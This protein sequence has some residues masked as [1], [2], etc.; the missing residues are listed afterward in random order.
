MSCCS[1]K[2]PA[3]PNKPL[4]TPTSTEIKTFEALVESLQVDL[5]PTED[6][7]TKKSQILQRPEWKLQSRNR[8]E[9]LLKECQTFADLLSGQIDILSRGLKAELIINTRLED[10]LSKEIKSSRQNP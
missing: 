4:P 3:N 2:T 10:T 5:I 9:I 1:R 6:L 7:K 8:M